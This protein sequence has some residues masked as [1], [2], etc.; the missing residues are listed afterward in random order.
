MGKKITT[1]LEMR[2]KLDGKALQEFDGL[3]KSAG[4]DAKKLKNNVVNSMQAQEQAAQK[5]AAKMAAAFAKIGTAALGLKKFYTWAKDRVNAQILHNNTFKNTGKAIGVTKSELKKLRKE[6]KDYTGDTKTSVIETQA[7]L[8]GIKG[9]SKDLLPDAQKNVADLAAK[10]KTD[11][12]SAARVYSRAMEHPAE[13]MRMLKRYNI[14]YTDSQI[15]M[16]QTLEDTGQLFKAQGI[17]IDEVKKRIGGLALE[18]NNSSFGNVETGI[19]SVKDAVVDL[20]GQL[21]PV[22]N[23]GGK[24]I[25]L[26]AKVIKLLDGFP[27]LLGA[28]A[29]AWLSLSSAVKFSMGPVG[30]VITAISALAGVLGIFSSN[31]KNASQSIKEIDAAFRKFHQRQIKRDIFNKQITDLQKLKVGTKQYKKQIDHILQRNKQLAQSNY[32]VGKSYQ[33]IGKQLI[34]IRDKN[35]VLAKAEAIHLHNKL[36]DRLGSYAHAFNTSSIND[37]SP[38]EQTKFFQQLGYAQ[39]LGEKH[40]INTSYIYDVI[41]KVAYKSDQSPAFKLMLTRQYAIYREKW[42]RVFDGLTADP[43]MNPSGNPYNWSGRMN[44]GGG[45]GKTKSYYDASW[46]AEEQA[47][48]NTKPINRQLI[49]IEQEYEQKLDEINKGTFKKTSDQIKA[50]QDLLTLYLTKWNNEQ[51]KIS[52]TIEKTE[53]EKRKAAEQRTKEQAQKEYEQQRNMIDSVSNYWSLSMQAAQ[54]DIAGA[55]IGIINQVASQTKNATLGWIGFAVSAIKDVFSI[56]RTESQTELQKLEK[57]LEQIKE[58]VGYQETQA[59]IAAGLYGT[60]SSQEIDEL[61]EGAIQGG[62]GRLDDLGIAGYSRE[63]VYSLFSALTGN[64][65]ALEQLDRDYYRQILNIFQTLNNSDTDKVTQSAAAKSAYY[66][67][68]EELLGAE[69]AGLYFSQFASAGLVNNKNS[70]GSGYSLGLSGTGNIQNGSFMSTWLETL[71][72]AADAMATEEDLRK[73]RELVKYQEQITAL[74]HLANTGEME[75]TE[76]AKR[77]LDIYDDMLAALE[78]YKETAENQVAI[79]QAINE[80]EEE[81]YSIQQSINDAK[82]E[83]TEIDSALLKGSRGKRLQSLLEQEKDIKNAIASGRIDE[84]TGNALL[85]DVQKSIARE[86][87]LAGA[88]SSQ[89]NEY[90]S[91]ASDLISGLTGENAYQSA[92]AQGL[93]YNMSVIPMPESLASSNTNTVN[94]NNTTSNTYYLNGEASS[95]SDTDARKVVAAIAEQFGLSVTY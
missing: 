76:V 58:A 84:S 34:N 30:W 1:I 78:S 69:L 31:T 33:E 27:L 92:A 10:M 43:R 95:L 17:L 2:S 61:I 55:S 90:E 21:A 85:A 4:I 62:Q 94:N 16:A 29:A 23:I 28:V 19:N 25:S 38:A 35:E 88:S 72:L 3:L 82:Y 74:D 46:I 20:F 42:K 22:I 83:E 41:R 48:L 80:L 87:V 14:Q 65:E 11:M 67:Q 93:A 52:E 68:V 45:N 86:L 49:K 60:G 75:S 56:F 64:R 51:K 77:K 89:I 79:Q 18:L 37:L 63:R 36:A 32:F 9:M 39:A 24:I 13:G 70:F 54:G 91:S 40:K 26:I 50:R 8:L 53:T 47:L 57:R 7:L 6:L 66:S 73:Q 5:S 59:S 71:G 15:K 12:P 81:R 44:T